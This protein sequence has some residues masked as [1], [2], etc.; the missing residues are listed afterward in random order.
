MIDSSVSFHPMENK[1]CLKN[2]MQGDYDKVYFGDEM[3]CNIIGKGDAWLNLPNRGTW[4]LIDV[5]HI[6][7]LKR[8]LIFV[9]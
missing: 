6:P 2:Y 5:R 3:T 7:N 1:E 9:S 8:I 4:L